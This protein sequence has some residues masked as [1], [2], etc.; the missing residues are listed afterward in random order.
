MNPWL[1]RAGGRP[2]IRPQSAVLPK[3]TPPAWPTGRSSRQGAPM[4]RQALA[5]MGRQHGLITH[6]QLVELGVR[7]EEVARLVRRREWVR[8]RK[9]VYAT[10]ALWEGLDEFRGRPV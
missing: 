7:P 9:G 10:R 8:V 3:R 4:D 2:R 5:V 1:Q 6:G